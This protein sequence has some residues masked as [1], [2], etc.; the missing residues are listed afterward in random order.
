VVALNVAVLRLNLEL[1]HLGRERTEL[2]AENAA[3]ASK[4]ASSAAAARIQQL[5]ARQL[6][7]RPAAP[8]QTRFVDIHP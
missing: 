4:L 3:L 5:A 7:V 6:G 1:D 2:K 8:E